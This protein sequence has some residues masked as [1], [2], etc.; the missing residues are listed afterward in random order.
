MAALAWPDAWH[1]QPDPQAVTEDRHGERDRGMC[2]PI[3]SITAPGEGL[4]RNRMGFK[5]A[6]TSCT[7]KRL[8][9]EECPSPGKPVRKAGARAA[10]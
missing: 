9:C 10:E 3:V 8:G 6:D 2:D 1:R 7:V 5:E 4:Y